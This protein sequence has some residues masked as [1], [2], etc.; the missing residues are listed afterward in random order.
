MVSQDPHPASFRF[1]HPVSLTG[2][3]LC[4]YSVPRVDIHHRRHGGDGGEWRHTQR[5]KSR[6]ITSLRRM[7]VTR[8]TLW[9]EINFPYPYGLSQA[10][11]GCGGG[12][13]SERRLGHLGG[14]HPCPGLLGPGGTQE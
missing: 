10:E 11:R 9:G 13:A 2:R 6:E 14:T 4:S 5:L 7:G 12:I 3:I 8:S 1:S